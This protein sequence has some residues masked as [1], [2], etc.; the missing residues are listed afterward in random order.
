MRHPVHRR[1][2]IAGLSLAVALVP[3]ATLAHHS[4]SSEFDVQRPV[5]V[6]GLV[7]KSQFVN[8][9]S[10]IYLDVKNQ[11]GSTTNWGFEFGSPGILEARHITKADVRAG[12]RVRITGFR[13]RN[14]GPYG[15]AQTV[16]LGDGRNI[17]IGSAPD[18]PPVRQA[19]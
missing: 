6:E 11:D 14:T 15:Y 12:T 9:H 8:P 17:P 2:A 10:W 19:R 16:V 7:T 13:S 3:S 1:Q 18:A 5:T 4:F